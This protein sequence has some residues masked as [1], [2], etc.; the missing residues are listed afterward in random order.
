MN[1]LYI[2]FFGFVVACIVPGLRSFARDGRLWCHRLG[3]ATDLPPHNY[4]TCCVGGV[5]PNPPELWNMMPRGYRP[6]PLELRNM[7][8]I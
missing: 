1:T 6:T 7:H 3:S 2:F 4:G 5:R 8:N